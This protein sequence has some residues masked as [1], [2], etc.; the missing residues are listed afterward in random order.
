M[1]GTRSDLSEGDACR[2][3][4]WLYADACAE[5]AGSTKAPINSRA[6]RGRSDTQRPQR[7]SKAPISPC[8]EKIEK[9]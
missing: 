4:V 2:H 6:V 5:T 3:T 8:K 1:N 9:G 7:A